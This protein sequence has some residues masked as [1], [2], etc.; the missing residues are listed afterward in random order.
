MSEPEP[1]RTPIRLG[2]EDAEPPTRRRWPWLALV[3][4]LLV[5]PG[6]VLALRWLPPPITAFMLQS[7]QQPV[8]YR[9]VPAAQH[10]RALRE[11]VIAAEDQKFYT[12]Q[13][14]DFE[15]IEKALEHN[16]KSRRVRGASTISQQVAKNL[17][18]WPGRSW[19]RKGLEVSF[20][21][22]IEGLWPK[23]R[24]LEVYLNVAE[25]GPGIYGAEA[26]ARAFFG[27]GSATLTPAECAHLAAVLPNPRRW[28]A[29]SP[30]PY[31]QSRVDWILDQIGE[32]PRY[33]A[34]PATDEPDFP[35]F[36]DDEEPP[37][38]EQA[39]DAADGTI[40]SAPLPN[41]G[42]SDAADDAA[43]P[44]YDPDADSPDATFDEEADGS[45]DETVPEDEEPARDEEPQD[46]PATAPDTGADP[47]S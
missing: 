2:R 25:F 26:A 8:Q 24:I 22:L 34:A 19:L 46:D 41:A 36:P 17:F 15:A 12:H 29:A 3:G 38:A 47:P 43:M 45:E 20:T 10:P 1:L 32:A 42:A 6:V 27:K 33:A 44:E 9:W 23:A 35:F 5:P 13:G 18:L 16:R 14:F 11:A 21:V 40:R 30:G 4:V 28:R 7:P 37:P 39:E 31:V